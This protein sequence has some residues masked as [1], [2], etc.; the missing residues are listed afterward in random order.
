LYSDALASKKYV[1]V[2]T[3]RDLLPADA[4]LPRVDASETEGTIAISSAAGTGLE[5][6]NEL[7]WKFVEREKASTEA[8]DSADV[9]H[10]PGYWE[11]M[12]DE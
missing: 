8:A 1:V 10:I 7:L 11:F 3:K 4:P 6:L 9:A 5:E 12:D 2:L